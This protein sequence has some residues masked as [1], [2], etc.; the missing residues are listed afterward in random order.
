MK[1]LT[2]LLLVSLAFTACSE[3]IHQEIDNQNLGNTE[4]VSDD[5]GM[6]MVYTFDPATG[7][8]SP[9]DNQICCS[10]I[11]YVFENLTPDL[12]L[13]FIPEVG[14]A[15]FDDTYDVH[16]FGWPL[17]P[18]LY[19]KVLLSGAEYFELV[20]CNLVSLVPGGSFNSSNNQLP[21]SPSGDLSVAPPS[22]G[23][24][25]TFLYEYGK[26]YAIDAVI[27]DAAGTIVASDRLRFPFLAPGVNQ[28]PAGSGFVPMPVDPFFPQLE[29]YDLWYHKDTREICIGNNPEYAAIGGAHGLIGRPSELNFMYNGTMRTL[30]LTTDLTTVRITLQ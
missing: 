21:M 10:F 6:N 4:N 26:I 18:A 25:W 11:D 14:M 23:A 12:Y 30:S 29:Q 19:G 17:N 20:E 9:F 24:E 8:Q 3:D 5:S 27:K 7:Y 15:R 22:S 13:E 1:K 2:L 16:H 28:P